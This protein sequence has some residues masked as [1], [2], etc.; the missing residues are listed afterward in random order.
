MVQSTF[1]DVISIIWQFERVGGISA[2]VVSMLLNVYM[3]FW[4][5]KGWGVI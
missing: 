3:F 1:W 5:L 2:I 4:A